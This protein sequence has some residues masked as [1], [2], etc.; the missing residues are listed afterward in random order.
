M[1]EQK[2]YVQLTL[3]DLFVAAAETL[4]A[5]RSKTKKIADD[6]EAATPKRR[7]RPKKIDASAE[8]ASVPAENVPVK[9]RCRPKKTE[10]VKVVTTDDENVSVVK[11]RGRPKKDNTD[12]ASVP[13]TAS[14]K[15]KETKADDNAIPE[16]Q[17]SSKKDPELNSE[18]TS[19]KKTSSA[20]KKT[21]AILTT[22]EE[23]TKLKEEAK[24]NK[25][26]PA[27]SSSKSKNENISSKSN[28][29]KTA[30]K[31]SSKSTF[32][33]GETWSEET[34]SKLAF[35]DDDHAYIIKLKNFGWSVLRWQ[36]HTIDTS[37]PYF[38][39]GMDDDEG[40]KACYQCCKESMIT[41]TTELP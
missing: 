26:A 41:Q 8:I 11:K 23:L 39:S 37:K 35:S 16:I 32:I 10:A 12:G 15:T 28:T 34:K 40:K 18:T 30:K 29:D 6:T 1:P 13:K 20:K 36:A 14:R 22:V 9:K 25:K 21:A 4:P 31:I 2:E 5:K 7:G 27:R 38:A 24:K 3:N 19:E 17:L 33:T